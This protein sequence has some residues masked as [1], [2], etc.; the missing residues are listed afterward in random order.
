MEKCGKISHHRFI[1]I[2]FQLIDNQVDYLNFSCL[3]SN[4]SI[5]LNLIITFWE[6]FFHR[7]CLN[8]PLHRLSILI[9]LKAWVNLTNS[10][11]PQ[12]KN[13]FLTS[14]KRKSRKSRKIWLIILELEFVHTIL[15]LQSLRS[16]HVLIFC[17][18][19]AK[20]EKWR[21]NPT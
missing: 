15:E 9:K 2:T 8:F 19:Y 1:V 4:P 5:P 12:A 18:Q 17:C 11:F 16:Y 20:A 21:E 7:R 6:L 10:A 3:L 14:K 13:L